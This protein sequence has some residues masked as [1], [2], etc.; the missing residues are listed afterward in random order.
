MSGLN[1]KYDLLG[2]KKYHSHKISSNQQLKKLV[3]ENFLNVLTLTAIILSM[4]A[5]TVGMANHFR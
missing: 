1:T 3:V 4:T 2:F 5:L